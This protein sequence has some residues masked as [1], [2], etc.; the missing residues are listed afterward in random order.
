M[1]QIVLSLF[2]LGI[3]GAVF[4]SSPAV[5]GSCHAMRPFVEAQKSGAHAKV[6]CYA[7]HVSD[8][9]WGIPAEKARELFRMYP[10]ALLG[11]STPSGPAVALSRDRCLS[12][13]EDVLHRVISR[14]GLRVNHVAC[15]TGT[16][17][18]D[19]HSA[20]PH[21]AAS[22]WIRQPDMR[23]CISCHR[24]SGA[25]VA[26]D[27]CH[28]GRQQGQRLTSGSWAI[29][30]GPQWRQTHG[31][32]DLRYCDACHT[33][34]YCATCHETPLPHA[35]GFYLDHGTEAMKP[36]AKCTQCHESSFCDGC[37]KTQMP[38]PAGFLSI[39]NAV[40][41]GVNDPVCAKC[42]NERDCERCHV[43]HTHPGKTNGW[44]G[45]SGLPAKRAVTP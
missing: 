25:A 9:I 31:M 3:A 35:Q 42:H 10:A 37:H 33:R 15:A 7:C 14:N 34:A 39:H 32:G 18:D 43:A 21:A 8:G 24:T 36:V 4:S 41:H 22:R 6:S 13:H 19:C 11:V 44:L 20:V 5:C 27:T 23:S 29:T 30:H 38:H 40:A 17:C 28:Q 26:C 2:L 1:I 12:C 16:T 45:S